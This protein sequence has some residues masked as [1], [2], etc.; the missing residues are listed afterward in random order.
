MG[1]VVAA[2]AL[3]FK[4]R[5]PAAGSLVLP[6][7]LVAAE[8]FHSR[9]RA[10]EKRDPAAQP[11]RAL[12]ACRGLCVR[13]SPAAE[14]TRERVSPGLQRRVC[15]DEPAMERP[16]WGAR[17][18]LALRRRCR[19]SR[20]STVLR[21]LGRPGWVSAAA[22]GKDGSPAWRTLQQSLH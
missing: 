20:G 4:I 5:A 16:P 15:G 2:A 12:A 11:F 14:K 21:S 10:G 18:R 6:G 19:L 7:L 1:S 13:S 3:Q 17:S 22:S 9:R 8:L